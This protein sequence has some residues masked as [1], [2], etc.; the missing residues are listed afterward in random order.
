MEAIVELGAS[1]EVEFKDDES[2]VT[3]AD[4]AAEQAITAILE[5]RY[6]LPIIAEERFS[7]G[8]V[9]E[10]GDVFFLVDPLDGTKSYIAGKPDYT[11]NIAVIERG[12]PIFGCVGVP[13]TGEVYYGG[14]GL[15]PTLERGDETIALAASPAPGPMRALVSRNHLSSTT[16]DYLDALDISGT[17]A[18]GSSLKFCLIAEGRGDLYPRFSRTMQWDTAAGD[19]IL[20]AAGGLTVTPSGETFVYGRTRQRL[21]DIYANGFFIAV[22]DPAILERPGILRST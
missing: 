15:A 8:R 3:R 11:V 13:E 20:R 4:R 17:I 18:I 1:G 7:D 14:L 12:F 21:E 10:V 22:G 5:A 2:P 9:P 6:T 19:A 16:K